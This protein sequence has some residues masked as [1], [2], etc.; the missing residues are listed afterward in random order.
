MTYIK[1]DVKREDKEKDYN[2]RRF[3]SQVGWNIDTSFDAKS[4]A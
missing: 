3:L 4:S 1:N 2:F